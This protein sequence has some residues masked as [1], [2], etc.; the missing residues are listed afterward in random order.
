MFLAI[1]GVIFADFVLNVAMG[2]F[3]GRQFM[4]DVSEMLVL[5]CASLA[6]VV[7]ILQR[8]AREKPKSEQSE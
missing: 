4:G 6:F 5:F 3:G 2:A 1:S 8:E 7:A